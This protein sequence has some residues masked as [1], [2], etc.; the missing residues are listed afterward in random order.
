MDEDATGLAVGSAAANSRSEISRRVA[1]NLIVNYGGALNMGLMAFQQGA[2]ALNWLHSSPYDVSYDPANYDP[3]YTGP[4]DSPTKK[5]REPNSSWPGNYIYFNVNLPFYDGSN[6]GSAFCYS[7]TADAFN[8]GEHPTLG[9]WDNYSVFARKIPP[10]TRCPWSTRR[11]GQMAGS[12]IFSTLRFFQPTVT[13]DRASPT[14]VA[15]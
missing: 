14:S 4:R 2:N 12:L 11:M 8:N 10:P 5:F 1:K 15:S 6:Q 13:W 3:S 9:P 7:R